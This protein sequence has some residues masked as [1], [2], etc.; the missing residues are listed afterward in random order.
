[1]ANSQLSVISNII[2]MATYYNAY[3]EM[4]AKHDRKVASKKE[5]KKKPASAKQPK[6]KLAIEKSSKPAPAPKPKAQG[7]AHV[8]GVAIQEPIA[9]AI[10]PLPV[11]EGKD[12]S[13][14]NPLLITTMDDTSS[15]IVRDSL[16]PAAETDGRSDKTSSGGD[17]EES[18][19]FPADEHVILED[20]LSST[21][22]LSSIMNLED[23][24]AIGDQ[25]INDKP[26]DDEPGKLNV[27]A[28]VVSMVTVLVYQ[29][30]SSVP[31][32][33]TPVIDLS[34]PKPAS[35][36]TQTPILTTTTATTK[37]PLPPPPQKIKAQTESEVKALEAV[38][39]NVHKD[40]FSI[41]KDKSRTRRHD[42]QDPPP[43]LSP[44]D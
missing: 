43:S 16:S 27:E 20:P 5:G 11:V 40:D 44:P 7:H 13:T 33:S 15:N 9:E 14:T 22:T 19:K 34:P 30:S 29:A 31:P 38:L 24:Y 6:P 28:E 25:F 41:E 18:L 2:R 39:R 8:G 12:A 10:R 17:T 23:A 36:T 35:F 4:V 1:M 37:T 26:T 21:G 32:L 42:D 3:L